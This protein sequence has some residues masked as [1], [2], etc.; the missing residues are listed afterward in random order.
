[1]ETGKRATPPR[2][3]PLLDTIA[4]ALDRHKYHEGHDDVTEL[5]VSELRAI[6][7]AALAPTVLSESK[8]TA[9]EPPTEDEIAAYRDLFRVELDKNMHNS[10][11]SP[12]TDAHR[13]A[14]HKFVEKRNG[15]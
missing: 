10:S 12:S 1:M 11:G 2:C 5:T 13:V 15:K 8:R 3:S 6:C 7:Q 14:L 9:I 4:N